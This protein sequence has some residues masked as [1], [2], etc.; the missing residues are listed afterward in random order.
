MS[1][2]YTRQPVE[3]ELVFASQA[4]DAGKL[5]QSSVLIHMIFFLIRSLPCK[6]TLEPLTGHYGLSLG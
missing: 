6:R 1:L 5:P 3:L 2:R 4:R